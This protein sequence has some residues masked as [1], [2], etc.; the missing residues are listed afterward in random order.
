MK[1]RVVDESALIMTDRDT[2]ATALDDL[3]AGHELPIGADD[4]VVIEDA[5]AFGHKIALTAIDA[6]ENV[7]KY[8][9]VIGKATEDIQ[10]GVWVHTHNCESTRGRG[11]V[12]GGAGVVTGGEHS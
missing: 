10:P 5:I 12:A 9:E 2:V 4:V 7:Y 11:D 3:E 8:G 6:D 1:G